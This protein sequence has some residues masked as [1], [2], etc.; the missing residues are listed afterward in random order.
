ME[1]NRRIRGSEALVAA[2]CDVIG[3][4]VSGDGEP[5]LVW[6]CSLAT[7]LG[8][9]D[10]KG[11][12]MTLPLDRVSLLVKLSYMKHAKQSSVGPSCLRREF[13]IKLVNH[14]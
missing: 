3:L 7:L 2:L 14:E 1:R 8:R 4:S 9:W 12:G 13:E 6:G 10:G 11:E 5:Q